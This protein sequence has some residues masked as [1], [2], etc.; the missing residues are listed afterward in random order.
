MQRADQAAYYLVALQD[1]EIEG[2]TTEIHEPN[3][4][5]HGQD[6][7]RSVELY[8]TGGGPEMSLKG[9][10]DPAKGESL[11]TE[12]RNLC[13]RHYAAQSVAI[14]GLKQLR[15]SCSSLPEGGTIGFISRPSDFE[16][17]PLSPSIPQLDLAQY[18]VSLEED[19]DF[20]Q[21]QYKTLLVFIYQTWE[22]YIRPGI[23]KL[24]GVHRNDVRCH[25]MGDLAQVRN[26]IIHNR[27]RVT[28][29]KGLPFLSQI[30]PPKGDE[31]IF[32]LDHMRD[33]MDQICSLQVFFE[34]HQI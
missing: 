10:A 14:L 13:H 33:L 11:L 29:D 34:N 6:D 18:K 15:D 32:S 3:Q 5:G 4:A 12:F 21:H 17:P 23:A 7:R 28:R 9:V 30:W 31:W 2:A 22:D 24:Y 20:T 1:F 8:W 25:L 27:G 19:G 16:T 26:D